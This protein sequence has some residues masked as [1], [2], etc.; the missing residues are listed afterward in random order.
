MTSLNQIKNMKLQ[1][2]DSNKLLLKV[3][4]ERESDKLQFKQIIDHLKGENTESKKK[5]DAGESKL[6]K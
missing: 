3:Q 2:S 6:Q 5:L 1:L 4:E